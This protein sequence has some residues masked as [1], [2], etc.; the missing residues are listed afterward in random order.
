MREDLQLKRQLSFLLPRDRQKEH[1]ES[2]TENRAR[3][4]GK[5]NSIVDFLLD[6]PLLLMGIFIAFFVVL[7]SFPSPDIQC[8]M[9]AHHHTLAFVTLPLVLVFS[10]LT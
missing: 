1:Q 8:M 2:E 3:Q 4:V 7:S 5:Y 6:W 9:G 10:L